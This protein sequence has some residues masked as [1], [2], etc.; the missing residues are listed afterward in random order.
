MTMS[1]PIRVN[2]GITAYLQGGLGNQLFIFAAAWEQATRLDCPLYIDRSRYIAR[3]RLDPRKETSRDFALGQLAIDGTVMGENSPWLR[4]YPRRPRMIRRPGSR[5]SDLSVFRQ[6]GFEYDAAINDVLPGTTLL[7]FFQSP[8]YFSTISDELEALLWGAS[9]GAGEKAIVESL[10]E[11]RKITVHMRR[12]DYLEGK[13]LAHHGIA[14][15]AYFERALL[16]SEKLMG[17]ISA[18]VFSDSPSIAQHE[19]E[20]RDDVHFFDDSGM[21]LFGTLLSMASGR[22]FVMSN[23]SFSWWGAWLLDRRN[24]GPVIAPRPWL[25][26]GGAAG[27]LLLPDWIT[28]D[29][30][31]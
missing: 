26:N 13:T 15:A 9:L 7:G 4:N 1:T 29:A 14:S 25:E 21:S 27:D 18:R 20:H 8:R 11:D 16:L 12:G 10:S 30:R 28:L 5:S 3:D 23:S 6:S 17:Q 19:L 31:Q 2:D 22:G 24:G